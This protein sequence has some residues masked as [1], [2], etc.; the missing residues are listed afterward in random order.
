MVM[1]TTKTRKFGLLMGVLLALGI[2][3]SL[4]ARGL[5]RFCTQGSLAYCVPNGD[6]STGF[7]CVVSGSGVKDCDGTRWVQL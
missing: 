1:K 2:T 4:H 3:T 7:D 6:G 5:I